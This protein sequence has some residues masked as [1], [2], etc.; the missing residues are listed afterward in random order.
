MNMNLQH[1]FFDCF[2]FNFFPV[3]PVIPDF[4]PKS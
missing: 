2:Y 1:I 3:L 4:S